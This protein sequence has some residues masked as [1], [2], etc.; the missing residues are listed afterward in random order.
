MTFF[1]QGHNRRLAVRLSCLF[2]L[3]KQQKTLKKNL[4]ILRLVTFLGWWNRDPFKWLLVT[5]NDRG[6]TGH[7]L[8]HLDF[9]VFNPS[10]LL[11]FIQWQFL[12]LKPGAWM[13]AFWS[14]LLSRPCR[15]WRNFA[16]LK[17]GAHFKRKGSS[18]LP[19]LHQFLQEGIC[20]I[21][22]SKGRYTPEN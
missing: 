7:G 1:H 20:Y 9:V 21:V 6:W 14:Q 4:A 8:N 22:F 15:E 17:R 2:V 3:K 13:G 5:S 11:R 18:N 19:S 12:H 16:P 10:C